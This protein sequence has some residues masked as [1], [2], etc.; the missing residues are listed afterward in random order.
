MSRVA[1]LVLAIVLVPIAALLSLV[2]GL[3]A[4]G[5]SM[6]PKD[7]T[8]PDP[9]T[10]PANVMSG[11]ERH[12]DFNRDW[13]A[14]RL[15]LYRDNRLFSQ[16][17]FNVAGAIAQLWVSAFWSPSQRIAEI[18]RQGYFGHG[19]QGVESAALGYFGRHAEQL[20]EA[21]V[22]ALAFLT[23][24]PGTS[25]WCRRATFER[26]ASK[27]PSLAQ[28]SAAQMLKNLLPAPPGACEPA[29]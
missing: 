19:F 5:F 10:V 18:A 15:F 16:R 13:Y 17:Q 4:W 11:F 25:P 2:L 1:K 28:V 14:T 22:A 6:F 21:E 9:A 26:R 24:S 12:L 20:S 3:L 23:R 27:V 8:A 29:A 7:V